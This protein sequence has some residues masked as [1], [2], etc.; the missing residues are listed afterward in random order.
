M[1]T[2]ERAAESVL[3]ELGE[4]ALSGGYS[5]NGIGQLVVNVDANGLQALVNSSNATAF[6]RDTTRNLRIKAAAHDGSIDGLDSAFT[7]TNEVEVEIFLNVEAI[8]YDINRDGSTQFYSLSG[9]SDQIEDKLME[10]MSQS[11]ASG[12]VVLEQEARRPVVRARI[13][14]SAFYGLIESGNVR[15][16]RP[17]GH[18]DNRPAQWPEEALE[19]ASESGQFVVS[20]ALRGGDYFSPKIGYMSEAEVEIQTNANRRAFDDIFAAANILVVPH[21]QLDISLGSFTASLTELEL[22]RLYELADERILSINPNFPTRASLG[23]SIVQVN[24]ASAWSSGYRGAGQSVVVLDTGVRKSHTYF[25]DSASPYTKVLNEACFGTD[26]TSGGITYASPCPNKNFTGDS[27]INE[28]GAGEPYGNA[29]TCATLIGECAHGTHVAG[30]VASRTLSPNPLVQ[31]VAP[32]ANIVA[33]QAGS[34]SDSPEAQVFFTSD[35]IAAL[36]AVYSATVSGTS[37]PFTLNMSLG[38]GLYAADCNSVDSTV[39]SG[40]NALVS[41]GVPVVVA[42]GNDGSRTGISWP[43]CIDQSIKVS[44]VEND[45]SGT[46]IYSDG[47]YSDPASYTGPFFLAPSGGGSTY[48]T[49]ARDTSDTATIGMQGTSQATPHVSG[50]YVLLK[51]AVPGISVADASAWIISTG[52]VPVTLNLGSPHGNKTFRRIEMP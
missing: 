17:I 9:M 41:R 49:S 12:V 31:G 15:A 32:D 27:P 28:P 39:T 7:T 34:Y 20:I 42:T 37:N 8:D 52:S 18:R 44:G 24:A 38:G 2:T 6:A 3:R 46:D 26:T 13:D 50:F 1:L 21:N 30:I 40:V 35:I 43:A 23:T 33:V 11:F 45:L 19:R 16:V 4:S 5:H 36:D 48:V 25:D 10:I 51:E 14:R 29:T 22:R 47:N